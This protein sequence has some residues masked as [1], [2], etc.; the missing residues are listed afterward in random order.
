MAGFA[1]GFTAFTTGLSD[2][3]KP[4]VRPFV[5]VP[6]LIG[7]LVVS[8]GM[9]AVFVYLED[10]TTWFEGLLP[11]WLSFLSFIVVPLI[12]LF[13]LALSAWLASFV[14]VILA[15]PVLGN[16]SQAVDRL[17]GRGGE[18]VETSVSAMLWAT[19]KRELIKL[20]YHL[21]RLVILVIFSL[22]P[23]LNAVAPALWWVFGAWMMAVQFADLAAENRGR[24]FQGTLRLLNE[25][26]TAA[27]GFGIPASFVLAIPLLNFLFVP[28]VA[29]G[30]TR[31]WHR[32]EERPAY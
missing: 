20:R 15:S 27:L 17:A 6:M 30:G 23:V 26:R 25:H 7:L 13:S 21:P 1:S 19:V 31:L 5:V 10:F 22:L 11:D 8:V 3:G 2:V 4:G 9:W 12:Y 32:L 29:A 24:E 14:A 28:A 18:A 16:L